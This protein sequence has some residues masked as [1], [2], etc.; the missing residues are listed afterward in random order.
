MIYTYFYPEG[1]V[2]VNGIG[3][4]EASRGKGAPTTS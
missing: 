3:R 2:V 1:Q 4:W